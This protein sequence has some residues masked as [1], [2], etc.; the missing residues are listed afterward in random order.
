MAAV[1]LG[2]DEH[3][4]ELVP[5]WGRLP[6]E[7]RYGYT[8][9]VC[10][11]SEGR[12]YIHNQSDH[13]MMVFDADGDYI[14]GWGSAFAQ[15]AHGLS[16]H[17]DDSGEF[18]FLSDIARKQVYK[19][20]LNGEILWSIGCPMDS[21]VY[22][23]PEQFVPTNTAVAPNGNIY[24]ADGYGKSYIHQYTPAGAYVRT[25][26]GPGKEPGQMNCPHGIWVDTRGEE[27]LVLV[28]DRA[29]ARLQWF[30]LDGA[31]VKLMDK[32]LLH[33]C[34]FSQRGGDLLVP[35]LFG[36]ISIFNADN[37][38][39]AHLGVTPGANHRPGYPNIPHDQRIPGKFS[40]PHAG[41]WD[42]QGNIY[43][44][45]WINDGRVTKLARKA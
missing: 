25:W 2:N 44:V 11:D 17:K 32:D 10:E 16:I 9:G 38:L 21:G 26:G 5:G 35:D 24:V 8:H 37:Y 6:G 1:I 18:L 31:F 30:T 3:T 33:P 43:I 27:P 40:S 42:S 45:E 20:T 4:Y 23:K 39:V 36:R 15:G 7:V 14:D 34:H 13:A 22:E 29:N 28:A 41:M 19:T 12:I